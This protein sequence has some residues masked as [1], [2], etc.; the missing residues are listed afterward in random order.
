[1]KMKYQHGDVVFVAVDEKEIEGINGKKVTI[2][3]VVEKGEGVHTHVITKCDDVMMYEKNGVLY[4]KANSDV[5][6]DHEEHK[7]K[8]LPKGKVYKKYIEN[9]YDA[10]KD[11]SF[12][13]RD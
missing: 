2:G 11:E 7:E 4:L 3:Y 12:K 6:I 5:V 10:E 1:M 13:T 8:V 9:E